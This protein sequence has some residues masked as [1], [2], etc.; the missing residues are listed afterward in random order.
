MSEVKPL[1][2]EAIEARDS[3]VYAGRAL[4]GRPF[5]LSTAEED[6]HALVA[7]V[8]RLRRINGAAGILISL[9][10]HDYM[11]QSH[12]AKCPPCAAFLAELGKADGR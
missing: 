12:V 8:K 11:R 10:G 7:E 9:T 3:A 4:S 6:R 1:D 2:L 5:V